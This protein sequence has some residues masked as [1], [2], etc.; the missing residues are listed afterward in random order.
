MRSDS[1]L[2]AFAKQKRRRRERSPEDLGELT[3]EGNVRKRKNLF[4]CPLEL[5]HSVPLLLPEE[6]EKGASKKEEQ[7]RED[8]EE[9]DKHD[10]RTGGDTGRKKKDEEE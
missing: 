5:L 6:L 7:Q 2:A 4:H 8:R 10:E 1:A 3:R 9:E